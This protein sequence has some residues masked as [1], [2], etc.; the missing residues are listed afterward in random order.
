[1]IDSD[2]I[3]ELI[4]VIHQKLLMRHMHSSASHPSQDIEGEI[5]VLVL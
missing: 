2:S 4:Q 3:A 5:E 1:L